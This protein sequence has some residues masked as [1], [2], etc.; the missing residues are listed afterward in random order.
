MGFNPPQAQAPAAETVAPG[1]PADTSQEAA[2]EA[3]QATPDATPA[4]EPA[5]PAKPAKKDQGPSAVILFD[6]VGE[7][8][9]GDVVPLSSFPEHHIDRLIEIGAI[10]DPDGAAVAP[11]E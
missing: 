7:F 8:A 2:Q 1:T 11:A 6:K 3:A 5:K 4:D 9:K 10:G